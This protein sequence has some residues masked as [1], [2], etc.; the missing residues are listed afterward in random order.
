MAEVLLV[1]DHLHLL[2]LLLLLKRQPMTF[3]TSFVQVLV[4]GHHRLYLH[5][6]QDRQASKLILVE[7]HRHLFLYLHHQALQLIQVAY[8]EEHLL[9]LRDHLGQ[10]LLVAA[11]LILITSFLSSSRLVG[12]QEVHLENLVE[13]HPDEHLDQKAHHLASTLVKKKL[14]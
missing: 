6:L 11:P 10:L 13:R 12:R 2:V 1:V 14:S 8:R 3:V 5:H 4:E 9:G 7:D